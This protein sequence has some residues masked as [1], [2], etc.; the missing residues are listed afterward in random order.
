MLN[1]TI[2]ELIYSEI[3]MMN[4]IDNIPSVKH[5][6]NLLNLIFYCLQPIRNILNKPMIVTSG[7]RCEKLNLLVGGK[8]NSQHKIGCA[9]DFVVKNMSVSQVIEVI[10]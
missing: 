2:S 1:F 9:I 8:I 3:A 5:L 7:Y 10:N 4:N 6:D